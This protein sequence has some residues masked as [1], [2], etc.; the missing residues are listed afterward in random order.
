VSSKRTFTAARWLVGL[1][2]MA[3]AAAS[4]VGLFGQFVWFLDLFA[5]F[6]MQLGLRS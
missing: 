6:R 2:T 4:A 1:A 3:F 5:H